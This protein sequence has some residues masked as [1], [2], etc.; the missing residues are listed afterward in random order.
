MKRKMIIIPGFGH[1]RLKL[2]KA[3]IVVVSVPKEIESKFKEK[4]PDRVIG[5][6]YDYIDGKRL[7]RLLTQLIKSLE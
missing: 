7:G 3:N 5:K 2:E 6:V 1:I 4:Y